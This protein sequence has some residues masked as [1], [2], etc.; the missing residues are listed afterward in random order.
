MQRSDVENPKFG[1]DSVFYVDK[2]VWI[3]EFKTS[4]TKLT[5]KATA[6]KV[7]EGV[8]SLF[9]K[10]NTKI[11]SLYD[12]K[13]NISAKSLPKLPELELTSFGINEE[14]A[15]EVGAVGTVGAVCAETTGTHADFI[16]Q[17]RYFRRCFRQN[18]ASAHK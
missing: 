18:N 5:E 2:T 1:V 10:G 7:A 8:D 11:A 13:T 15:G 14:T 16:C 9:C 4:T 17:S 6:K 12:C 3:F